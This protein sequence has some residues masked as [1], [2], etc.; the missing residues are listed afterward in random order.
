MSRSRNGSADEVLAALA[1]N[2]EAAHV[3]RPRCV[4]DIMTRNVWSCRP[5][6]RL[7]RCAQLMWEHRCGATPVIDEEGRPLAMITDRDVAMAALLQGGR[8]DDVLVRSAM[9]ATVYTVHVDD[10]VGDAERLMR[11]A[12]VRRL[13]VVDAADR[14]VGV[15]SIDDIAH[16]IS[17]STGTIEP[18]SPQAFAATVAALGHRSRPPR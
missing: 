7:S 8:L 1:A 4:G 17:Q 14:L 2:A 12:G 18:L 3:D 13:P 15:L 10:A 11:R 5:G 6:D 9:S 16:F